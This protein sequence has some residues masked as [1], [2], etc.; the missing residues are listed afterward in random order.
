LLAQNKFCLVIESAKYFFPDKPNSKRVNQMKAHSKN[1]ASSQNLVKTTIE[2]PYKMLVEQLNL[3]LDSTSKKQS[4]F[5]KNF[6]LVSVIGG[7]NEIAL[8][9][10]YSECVTRNGKIEYNLVGV[11]SKIVLVFAKDNSSAPINSD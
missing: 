11:T 6:Q 3:I 2:L 9:S 8:K 7:T 4:E 1:L 5:S 10:A